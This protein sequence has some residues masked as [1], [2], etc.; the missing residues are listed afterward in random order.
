MKVVNTESISGYEIVEVKG[1][2]RGSTIQ[3]RHIGKD[4][5]AVLKTLVG[6]EIRQYAEMLDEARDLAVDRMVD[7]AESLG[8]NA[9]VNVRFT[10]ATVMQGAAEMMAYGT[11]VVVRPHG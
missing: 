10:T 7:Q 4:L 2:V 6:G 9:V 11:A 8:A 5:L 3:S 1:L